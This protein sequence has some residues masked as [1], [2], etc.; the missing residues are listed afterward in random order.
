MQEAVVPDLHK[1]LWQDM[2]QI[3]PN[4]LQHIECTCSGSARTDLVVLEGDPLAVIVHDSGIGDGYPE[5]ICAEIL[6]HALS[7]SYSLAMYNPVFF[8]HIIRH[9]V[10]QTML[11]Q[12]RSELA[13]EQSRESPDMHEEV[14]ARSQP[15]VSI[16][17]EPSTG[18]DIVDVRMILYLST[19]RMEDAKEAHEVTSDETLVGLESLKAIG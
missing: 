10:V 9:T 2:L 17:G 15:A 14:T 8:P 7:I 19:P 18:N 3:A 12:F 11:G 1:A 6:E 4:E 5:Y 16:A 13:L